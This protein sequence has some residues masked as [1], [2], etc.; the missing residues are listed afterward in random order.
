MKH[1]INLITVNINPVTYDPVGNDF[2]AAVGERVYAI[3]V[4]RQM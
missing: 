2:F 4:P 1:T 3:T